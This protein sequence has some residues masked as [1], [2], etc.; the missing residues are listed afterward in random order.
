MTERQK[1]V[2]HFADKNIKPS[3]T[4]DMAIYLKGDSMKTRPELANEKEYVDKVLKAGYKSRMAK[5]LF[6]DIQEAQKQPTKAKPVEK[7]E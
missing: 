7:S 4:V 6:D 5:D 1:I 3:T 2:Q